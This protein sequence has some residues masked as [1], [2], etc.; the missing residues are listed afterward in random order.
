LFV[1]A[2]I[3]LLAALPASGRDFVGVD[4]H[5]PGV[6][7]ASA[8]G[9]WAYGGNS[10]IAEDWEAHRGLRVQPNPPVSFVLSKDS[11][12]K[13]RRV[14]VLGFLPYW[15]LG[16][17]ILRMDRLTTIAYFAVEVAGDGTLGDT[18]H[19]GTSGM[20]PVMDTARSSGVRVVLVVTCFDAVAM[21][22]LLASAAIRREAVD[23]IV[24]QV[25]AAGG[26]GVNVDFEGLPVASKSAFVTFV[27]ELKAAM[28]KS[29]G[30]SY[31]TVDT[32]AV[33]WTGAYDYDALA[34]AG[35]GLVI[36]GYDYHWRG[37]D[38]GP[39]APLATVDPTEKSSLTWTLDD[40]DRWGGVGNRGRFLLAL[41]LYGYDWPVEAD[42]APGIATGSATARSYADCGRRAVAAGGWRWDE[43][44][45]TPWI[46]YSSSGSWRQLWCE[47]GESL[48]AKVGLAAARSLG[49]IA[50][51]ALGYE[52]DSED[53][54]VALDLAYPPD[55]VEPVP[56]QT[57]DAGEVIEPSE[58][59]GDAREVIELLELPESPE[60][61]G[62]AGLEEVN[63]GQDLLP[64]KDG[65]LEMPGDLATVPPEFSE[66]ASELPG[67][68]ETGRELD[69]AS[70]ID[71]ATEA[72][73]VGALA[74]LGAGGCA[75]GGGASA[76]GWSG[77]WWIAALM[78][79]LATV[80]ERR[81]WR[82]VCR[83]A[84]PRGSASP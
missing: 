45:S 17:A 66:Q 49:G 38:P 56:E 72:S 79:V 64:A 75:I 61:P 34:L 35:D 20:Q 50:Y 12:D 58:L 16:D 2:L 29:L 48:A 1:A 43:V 78:F 69:G 28:D 22:D 5:F 15:N 7:A 65:F 31:V 68:E 14:E 74:G 13:S 47:N 52:E 59:P 40:Y 77:P 3:G 19:W 32:P 80:L 62:D 4:Q 42:E 11:F 44:A 83:R 8:V 24:A 10:R 76:T 36:M 23:G 70:G 37:G 54:W 82:I 6:P 55:P 63:Q 51:W 84:G 73:E 41:P 39:V 25:A 30:I 21:A 18:R 9:P 60:L 53:P 33:D 81:R 46:G 57:G 27:G 71:V 26:D 67:V